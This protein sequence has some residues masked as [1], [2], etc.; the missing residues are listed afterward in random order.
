MIAETTA[1]NYIEIISQMPADTFLIRH[2]V[3]WEEY[4][5]LLDQVGEAPGLRISYD[6]GTLQIMTVGPKH[7]NYSSFIERLISQL[8]VRLRMNIRFFGSST[9]KKKNKRKGLE[10]D[11]CFYVQ[12]AD[13]LGNRMDLDFERDPPPDVAVEVDVTRHSISKFGI[14]AGLDVPEVWIY[15]GQELKIYLLKESEYVLATESQALPMLTGAI[16]THFLTRL[17]EDGELQTILAFDEW[18]QSQKQTPKS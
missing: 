7:E 13:A 15:D 12:T 4:E 10:P 8:S 1:T 9:M 16:L 3:S 6:D 2:D 18:L 5:D 17:R 14:Y 11:A